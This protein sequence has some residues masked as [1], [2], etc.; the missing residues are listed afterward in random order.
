[1]PTYIAIAHLV[2]SLVTLIFLGWVA[3]RI[4]NKIALRNLDDK[5]A[6]AS[7]ELGILLHKLDDE[8]PTYDEE[9]LRYQVARYSSE[10]L[11]NRLSD[12]CHSLLVGIAIIFGLF[13]LGGAIALIWLT[14][15]EDLSNAVFAWWW[16]ATLV[17]FVIVGI[18][19]ALTCQVLTGRGVGEAKE[20]RRLMISSSYPAFPRDRKKRLK[21]LESHTG[22]KKKNIRHVLIAGLNR[23]STTS[24]HD[25]CK[26]VLTDRQQ[27]AYEGDVNC[28]FLL[29]NMYEKGQG[30]SQDYKAAVKW[31]RLAADQGDS[32]AQCYLGEM[33]WNG[34]GVQQ[35][36]VVAYALFNISA[37]ASKSNQR[38]ASM[39]RGRTTKNMSSQQ[40]EAG[41]ALSRKMMSQGIL[42]AWDAYLAN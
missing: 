39:F 12:M 28:Q 24:K 20:A 9:I 38:H 30:V 33:Y 8:D 32:D 10:L 6:E 1:M 29:G 14:F 34:E 16:A 40:V 21:W 35:D 31:Y 7:L 17:C 11:R 27:R 18:L 5:Y 19:I 41:Q 26:T 37:A 4:E 23:G 36:M 22:T 15:V 3:G 25:D 13:S 2:G 42:K